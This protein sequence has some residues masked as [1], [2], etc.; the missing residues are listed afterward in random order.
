MAVV[1]ASHMIVAANYAID[2]ALAS[3][4]DQATLMSP[5]EVK[6]GVDR[7]ESL[8]DLPAPDRCATVF[9]W[10]HGGADQ[11]GKTFEIGAD[12]R[13]KMTADEGP[14]LMMTVDH[15]I[16]SAV[17]RDMDNL[18]TGFNRQAPPI[19]NERRLR[20]VISDEVNEPGSFRVPPAK[21]FDHRIACRGAPQR[22]RHAGIKD[23]AD[24]N[25]GIGPVLLKEA[26][27]QIGAR[28]DRTKVQVGQEKAA[29]AT[30]RCLL[31]CGIGQG[32]LLQFLHLPR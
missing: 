21:M 27:N 10:H 7:R 14:I 20:I 4:V 23:V 12:A 13:Q 8:V 1:Q 3:Q 6:R 32:A 15:Q 2:A 29:V 9:A 18:I 17:G 25:V 19:R 26:N 22:E 28:T 31:G 5:P 11:A 24:E 16:S 30:D